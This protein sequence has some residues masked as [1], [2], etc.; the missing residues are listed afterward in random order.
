MTNL[1]TQ[2]MILDRVPDQRRGHA[3]R[4]AGGHPTKPE[5][6]LQPVTMI[7]YKNTPVLKKYSLKG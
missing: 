2:R 4:D 3:V 6:E 1:T 5:Q 7:I